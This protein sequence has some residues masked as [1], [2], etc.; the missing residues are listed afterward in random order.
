MKALPTLILSQRATILAGILMATLFFG[1]FAFRVEINENPEELIFRGDPGYPILKDFYDEFGHDEILMAAYSADN[2]MEKGHL[3]SIRGLTDEIGNLEAVERVLSLGNAEDLVVRDGSIE[4]APLVSRLPESLLDRDALLK[5]IQE[6]PNYR[7]LLLSGDGRSALLDITLKSDLSNHER[8]RVL[9]EI[10]RILAAGK[11]TGRTRLGGAPL[12]R[13]EMF[14]CVRR[15]ART[16]FP[17]AALLLMG[18]MAF[19]FRRFLWTLL[20]FLVIGLSVLW[21]L[22]MM[23]A[24]GYELNFLSVLIPTI[25]FIIGTSDC[26]H[27]LCEYQDNLNTHPSKRESLKKTLKIMIV[28]CLLTTLT[29]ATGFLSLHASRIE[30]IRNFGLFSACGIFFSYILCISLL[31]AA[32]TFLERKNH[33]GR[34]SP[35]P[36]A[37]SAI[38]DKTN[39]MIVTHRFPLLILSLLLLATGALGTR[40]L[41][42]ETDL[43]NF[44]GK[45]V[46]GIKETLFIEDQF[47]GLLPLYV[48][49]DSGRQDG[50]KDPALLAAMDR[51][52]EYL[53]RQDGVTKVL[54]ISDLVK[55]ANYR[56]HESNPGFNRIPES[57][58]EIAELLLMAELSDEGD[59]LRRFYDDGC[60]VA[61]IGIRYK[62]HDFFRIERMKRVISSYLDEPAHG[63]SSVETHVTGTAFLCANMMMPILRGLKQSL[64]LALAAIFLLMVVLFRSLRLGL[65]SMVPNL[66]P[67]AMTL[68]FMGLARISLNIATAPVAAVALGLAVDDTIHFLSRFRREFRREPNYQK[69]I[70]KTV[71]RAG[72]PILV[73]SIVLAVGFLALYASNFHPTRNLGIL[74]SLT[75]VSAVFA[76]LILLPVLLLLLKP[77]GKESPAELRTM[78]VTVPVSSGPAEEM[79]VAEMGEGS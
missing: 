39:A 5:R 28:P 63:L 3:E 13:A 6:N 53:R 14:R 35:S 34:S 24:T 55:Y 20:T 47:G 46:E 57:R 61:T 71:H 10:A 74:I 41:H 54:S 64:F 12:G 78:E 79:R 31:P 45:N 16:L 62:H 15:D 2:V 50:L 29:T 18:C 73:T 36:G 68:G 42:V 60:S 70:Q 56:L 52:S 77:L 37:L 32:L 19:I 65:I 38:L 25:L 48:V 49:V 43:A 27:I 75:V 59:M 9:E 30:P 22:G 58:R 8:E 33:K 40:K 4:I 76:D 11:D 72:R 21:T 7:D 23:V 51:M 17:L 26:V 69:A 66:V 44:F 1:L 67:I